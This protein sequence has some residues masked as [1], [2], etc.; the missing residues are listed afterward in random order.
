MNANDG[1]EKS[2]G[3]PRRGRVGGARCE[4]ELAG[5]VA[6]AKNFSFGG[7][8]RAKPTPFEVLQK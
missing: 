7:C 6:R 8:W 3:S 4:G 2:C 1:T 5:E